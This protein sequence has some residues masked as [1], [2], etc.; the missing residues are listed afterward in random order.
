[1][2][3]GGGLFGNLPATKNE[4]QKKKATNDDDDNNNDRSGSAAAVAATTDATDATVDPTAYKK[5]LDANPSAGTISLFVPS[6]IKKHKTTTDNAMSF[7]PTALRKQR[8]KSAT[9]ATTATKVTT[10]P[11]STS[12]SMTGVPTPVVPQKYSHAEGSVADT[13]QELHQR[14]QQEVSSSSFSSWTIDRQ[15]VDNENESINTYSRQGNRNESASKFP[16]IPATTTAAAAAP[17]LPPVSI[18]NEEDLYDPALPNDLLQYWER[19]KAARERQRLEKEQADRLQQQE[20]L[21]RAAWQERQ[22]LIETGQ[23]Q[24]LAQKMTDLP[25]GRG[26]GVSNIPA[27]MLKQQQQRQQEVGTNAETGV[28]RDNMT[29]PTNKRRKREM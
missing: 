14:K 13:A 26:R 18:I 7:L 11:I 6:T 2:V 1:M 20:E 4:G 12:T 10:E 19:A 28:G 15:G 23:Y 25:R 3:G 24:V 22:A 29:E 5:K 17:P 21:R 9:A 27:W 8:P 16:S